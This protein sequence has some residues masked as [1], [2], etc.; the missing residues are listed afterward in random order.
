MTAEQEHDAA[1][2]DAIMKML[3]DHETRIAALEGLGQGMVTNQQKPISVKEFV[4]SKKPN[5]DTR[6]TLAI[7]YF[8][9]KYEK[10]ASFN[11]RDLE[12]GF[13]KGK[14]KVP[15]NINDKV[16]G[17]IRN[18][19]MMVASEQKDGLTA[20]TLTNSGERFVE[21]NFQSTK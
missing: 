19:H 12:E 4:L 13:R 18:G 20:W 10:A 16:N 21:S 8:L 6:R 5:D 7:G 2:I 9:E 3:Q 15:L 14:E 1:N 11:I 17:N